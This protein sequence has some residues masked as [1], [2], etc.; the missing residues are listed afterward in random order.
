MGDSILKLQDNRLLSPSIHEPA[1][2]RVILNHNQEV[3]FLSRESAI[4]ANKDIDPP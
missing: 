4:I 2:E 3:P 1:E